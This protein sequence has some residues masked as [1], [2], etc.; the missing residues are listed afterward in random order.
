MQ[1]R[2]VLTSETIA[3]CLAVA[4][5]TTTN[6][7]VVHAQVPVQRT[8]YQLPASNGY[9]AII[10]NLDDQNPA[11]S[12]R[13]VHFREHLF[14]AEEPVID[15]MGN[16]VWNG[17]DFAAVYTRDLLYDAY[18]GLRDGNGQ[19]WLPSLPVDLDASGY[20]SWQAGTTGGTGVITMVQT[21]GMLEATQ[22]FFAPLELQ[23]NAF[24]MAMRVRNTGGAPVPGAQAFSLHNFHLGYGRAQSPWEV[25]QDIGENGETLVFDGTGGGAAFTER[26]FAGVVAMRAAGS[27]AHYG[28]AP[29]VN[30]YGIVNAGGFAD[31]P[32]NPTPDMAATGATGALQFD[33]GDLMPGQE[34]WVAVT[35]VHHGDPF[36]GAEALGLA[37]G[38]IAGRDAQA[39]VED[40]LA[41]WADFQDTLAMPA[42]Q[43]PQEEVLT[44]QSAAMLRMGQVREDEYYL[45]E[46]QSQDG[47][48]RRTRFPGTLP[49]VVQ[50][51]GGGAILASLPPGNWTYAWIR[52]GAYATLAMATLGMDAEARASLEYYLN[53]EAGRF[54]DWM[55]L[56]AY[57]MPDYQISL[58]RY[59]GFGIEET[60]FNAFG[61]NLEFDGFG[62]FL[63]A[64]RGYEEHTG[65]RTLAEEYWPT[66]SERVADVIVALVDPANG[67][68]RRDSSIWES[69]WNGRE[70]YWAYTSITAARGLCDAAAIAERVGDDER[71]TLYRDT[72]NGLRQAILDELSDGDGAIASTR[73]ELQLG[74]GYWDAA[75]I[76]AIAMG[77]YDP[78]GEI[79][80]ATLAGL[81]ANLI[82][83]ASEVGWSRNDDDTDHA[84]GNDLSPWGSVYDSVEWVITDLRGS[85]AFRGAGDEARAE[86]MLQWIREQA[87]ANYLMVAE[88]FNATTG[89]Y[90]NNTPMLGFGAGAWTLAL[91]HRAGDFQ[92]A[93]CGEYWVDMSSGETTGGETGDTT[94]SG[95]SSGGALDTSGG[96][97]G[98]GTGGFMTISAGLDESSTGDGPGQDDGG[99]GCGCRSAGGGGLPLGLGLLGLLGL[100]RRRNRVGGGRAPAPSVTREYQ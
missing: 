73:E 22:Y 97:G 38:W 71:A 1:G 94:G 60:D 36:A 62:L 89:V 51:D 44:R 78:Q 65:D 8:R 11:Q 40:E 9:G 12:R 77:L 20:A 57:D 87:E 49:G 96:S 84:G 59:Y 50:H 45:R 69:H 99:G 79:A 33:L 67:L 95:G 68:I 43:S 3:L 10:V 75:V 86:A 16:E 39:L 83:P 29:D 23:S 93:A 26:G 64:L 98:P 42:G 100:W 31:L 55:E 27:V 28:A 76:D 15:D 92:D 7:R 80:T 13:M 21:M 54:K 52:D 47:E 30:V 19:A 63:W 25:N 58:V 91:A 56:A 2:R 34:A 53:A 48:V 5:G 90:E 66:I 4:W 74:E 37:D 82:T 41:L 17:S 32:D 6:A 72:A 18:F 81:D 70:R 35:F 14:A 24:V 85:M 46:W 61:P 88:T